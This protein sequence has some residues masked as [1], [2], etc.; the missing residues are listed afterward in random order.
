V[1]IEEQCGVFGAWRVARRK[2]PDAGTRR[3][4]DTAKREKMAW[5]NQGVGEI[6]FE[7]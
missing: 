6:K 4:G 5:G 3:H 1:E 2:P 7:I